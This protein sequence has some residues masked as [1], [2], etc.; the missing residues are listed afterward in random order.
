MLSSLFFS[1][2]TQADRNILSNL[3]EVRKIMQHDHIE[4]LQQLLDL[5][6]K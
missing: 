1:P 6:I 4:M 3:G 5:H 2:N